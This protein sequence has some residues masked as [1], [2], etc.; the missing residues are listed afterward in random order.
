MKRLLRTAIKL[1]IFTTM[2]MAALVVLGIFSYMRLGVELMPNMEFPYV[3][4]QTTLSGASPEEIETSVTK[5]IEEAVN[6]ISGIDELSSYSNESSS[7]VVVKFE[8]EKNGDVG[9]QE[10]RDKVNSVLSQLP[11]GTKN[12]VI[13]K[14]DMDSVPVVNVVVSGN[15]SIIDLTEFAKK[16]IKERLET[17]SGV[18]SVTLVGGQERE[19]HIVVNPLK[20]TALGVTAAQVKSALISQ[21]IEIPGGKVEQRDTE[22]TLRTLGRITAVD[23]FKD[24]VVATRNGTP[25]R[26]SDF[27]KV[28]DTGEYM[29]SASYLNGKQSVTLVIKKQSGSNVVGTVAKIRARV[30]EIN[31]TLPA[32]I[33]TKIIGDQSEFIKASVDTVKEHLVLGSL[34]AALMVF[35]FMGDI[36]STIISAVA[37]PVSLIA[38]FTFMDLMGFTLNLMTLMGLTVAVGLVID[39]AIVMLENIYRHMEVY[40]LEP[41]KAALNGASEIAFAVLAMSISLIVIFVPLAYMDGIIG[42]VVKSYGLTIACAIAVS[43]F[44][45]LTLTPMLCSVFLT[46]HEGKSKMQ[47]FTD[48]LNNWLSS[49]YVVMLEWALSHRKTMVTM[50]VLIMLSTV[51]LAMFIGKD[52]MPDDDTSQY[53]INVKAPEGTSLKSMDTLFRQLEAEVRTIPWVTNTLSAIGTSTRNTTTST[54][55]GYIT[56]E[57]SP[58]GT[59]PALDK[60]MDINRDML[61]KYKGLTTS[62]VVSGGFNFGSKPV[63]YS[64]SGPDLNKLMSYA[65]QLKDKMA[66]VPGIVDL[67]LSFSDAQPEY[68]VQINRDKAHDLGVSVSDIASALRTMVG[69]EEDV[70]KYK[71]GDELYEVRVRADKTYRT[72]KEL[73][74]AMLIPAKD[75]STVRLDSVASV[76]EGSGPTRIDRVARQRSI[77]VDGNNRGISLSVALKKSNQF[78]K[79]LKAP[80]DYVGTVKGSGKEMNKMLV[81]F[82]GAFAMAFIFIYIVLA[83]QFESFVYPLSIIIALPLTLPFAFLTLFILRQNL[84]LFSILGLFMLFGVVKKNSILIVDYTNTLRGKGLDRHTACIEANRTRLRPILMTTL[85]L[86][87]SMIPTALGTGSGSGMRHAMAWVIIGGQALSLLITLLMTPVSYTLFDDLQIWF[88]KKFL[89][90]QPEEVKA[91]R[92]A[93]V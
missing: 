45:A 60:I 61:S 18:G 65:K 50:A 2:M 12:P 56:V 75:G 14:R 29:S 62:V 55:Q 20:M 87:A 71:E 68:R 58:I 25:I 85:T 57:V 16:K 1:P 63:E 52:M 3:I 11:D 21:N 46:A 44:V 39:D 82:I 47:R 90:R 67:E 66:G 76:V 89:H 8:L 70:T 84:T 72:T 93:A 83:S 36:R 78:F 37:I 49:K 79:E 28:E 88:E 4:V 33:Q 23:Q 19:I 38:T 35:I 92:E 31:K 91:K 13:Q 42:R 54:N 80:A 51:P 22:Y 48:R 43:T 77:S 5:P 32:D 73:I 26:I 24:V 74:S 9:A 30:A 41:K 64:I 6:G 53:I 15:R 59:R 81:S 40:H 69:G 7:I 86:I 10:V 34:L 27:A 17:V